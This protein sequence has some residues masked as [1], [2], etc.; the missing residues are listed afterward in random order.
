MH[1]LRDGLT[2]AIA[3]LSPASRQYFLPR[4][5]ESHT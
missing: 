1:A 3:A 4:C 5:I 2:A